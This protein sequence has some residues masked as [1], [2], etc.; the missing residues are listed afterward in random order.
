MAQCLVKK[1]KQEK[2]FKLRLSFVLAYDSR[3]FE[4]SNCVFQASGPSAIYLTNVARSVIQQTVIS[5]SSE[6]FTYMGQ[7]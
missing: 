7:V 6:A 4:L 2:F 3:W 5:G 1:K